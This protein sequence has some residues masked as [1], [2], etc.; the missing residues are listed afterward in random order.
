MKDH[1]NL[2]VHTVSAQAALFFLEKNV[3]FV[4]RPRNTKA[5]RQRIFVHTILNKLKRKQNNALKTKPIIVLQLSYPRMISL[6]LK[7]NTTLHVTQTLLGR[8]KPV[9]HQRVVENVK[10]R[11]T[12]ISY[13]MFRRFCIYQYKFSV[14]TIGNRITRNIT[15]KPNAIDTILNI[16]S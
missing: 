13:P 10:K 4:I 3:Y 14:I 11:M 6:E 15:S 16:D 12:N 5:R 2:N 1:E 9:C 8:I 7:L